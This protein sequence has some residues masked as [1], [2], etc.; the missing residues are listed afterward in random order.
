MIGYR[1][2]IS[3]NIGWDGPGGPNNM[4]AGVA[5]QC[6]RR[7]PR[8]NYWYGARCYR[9]RARLGV[10][11]FHDDLRLLFFPVK[12]LRTQAPHLSWDQKA[13]PDLIARGLRQLRTFSGLIALSYVGAGN[14]G[15][16]EALVSRLIQ[17]E[18][19]KDAEPGRFVIV[20][21]NGGV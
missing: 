12:P 19:G 4:G 10:I 13:C 11:A 3:T 6:L 21:W 9:S 18:L 8:I 5:L 14:G 2:V 20:K 7:Y 15:L 16:D 1:I 17:A